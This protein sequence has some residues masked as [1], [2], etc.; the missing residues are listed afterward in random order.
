MINLVVL[1]ARTIGKVFLKVI[2]II[3]IL[4]MG[5]KLVRIAYYFGKNKNITHFAFSSE[6]ILTNNFCFVR[7]FKRK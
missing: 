5:I 3:F 1:N 4:I 7:R 2:S 6:N